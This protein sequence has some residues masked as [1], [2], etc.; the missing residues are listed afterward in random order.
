MNA[1]ATITYHIN[2]PETRVESLMEDQ[3][4]EESDEK[5]YEIA[6]T[7]IEEDIRDNPADYLDW[8]TNE[9]DVEVDA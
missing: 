6:V 1:V 8:A 7:L 4:L 9:P 2:V 3:G 5:Y